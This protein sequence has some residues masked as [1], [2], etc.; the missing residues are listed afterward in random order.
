MCN[1]IF[2]R[3]VS[4]SFVLHGVYAAEALHVCYGEITWVMMVV[5]ICQGD[6]CFELQCYAGIPLASA[7]D[8]ETRRCKFSTAF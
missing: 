7:L 5:A 3:I 1:G 4:P 2:S 8:A 6:I